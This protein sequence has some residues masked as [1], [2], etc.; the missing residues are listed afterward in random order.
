[1]EAQKS[2][3]KA[4]AINIMVSG[5]TRSK[6]VFLNKFFFFMND[7]SF[8]VERYDAQNPIRLYTRLVY[9]FITAL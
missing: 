7:E 3:K 8:F 1:M 9:H 2:N 6:T 4:E 5:R